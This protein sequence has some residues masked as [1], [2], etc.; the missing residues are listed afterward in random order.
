MAAKDGAIIEL[1]NADGHLRKLSDIENDV[2]TLAVGLYGGSIAEVSRRLCIGR[3][4]LYRKLDRH[5]DLSR[6]VN[7][8]GG[9]SL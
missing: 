5:E 7:E 1:Y 4:T 8:P 6:R 2:I 3:S 9:R